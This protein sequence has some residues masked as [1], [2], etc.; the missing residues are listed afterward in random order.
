MGISRLCKRWR[1]AHAL[2]HLVF[3]GHLVLP[4]NGPDLS[5]APTDVDLGVLLAV[6]VENLERGTTA[7]LESVV[8]FAAIWTQIISLN[9][10]GLTGPVDDDDAS[11]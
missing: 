11:A 10:Q 7:A 3:E 2:P 1:G 8:P 6:G 4:E 5:S 9:G